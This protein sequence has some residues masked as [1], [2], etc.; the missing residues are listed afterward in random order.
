MTFV[1]APLSAV[2]TDENGYKV[3]STNPLPVNPAES[4]A[5]NY[6]TSHVAL[7]AS[8]PTSL[9]SV[10]AAR[11]AVLVTNTDSSI[12][13]YVGGAA[14]SSTTGHTLVAG[15]SLTLPVTGAVYGISASGTP[16]V[17]VTEVY[18]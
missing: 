6:A 13:V 7:N 3:D 14:V 18:D 17:A 4:G 10:R 8:T 12:T 9:V 5:A 1:K 11:R 16:S 15:A 2:L